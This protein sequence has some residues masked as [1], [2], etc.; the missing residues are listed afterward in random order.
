MASH[1]LTHEEP[2]RPRRPA[3]RSLAQ[4]GWPHYWALTAI[5]GG[6]LALVA[7]VLLISARV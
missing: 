6:M 1:A 4:L 3:R 7:L 5:L 2:R